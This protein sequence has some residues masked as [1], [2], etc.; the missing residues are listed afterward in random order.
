MDFSSKAVAKLTTAVGKTLDKCM[1]FYKRVLTT[2]N[3]CQTF[4]AKRLQEFPRHEEHMKYLHDRLQEDE[5]IIPQ[6]KGLNE[7]IVKSLV[8]QAV[9]SN[10]LLEDQLRVIPQRVAKIKSQLVVHE[11]LV[12]ILEPM[13]FRTIV[14]DVVAWKQFVDGLVGST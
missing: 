8:A 9:V 2:Q 5:L 13:D 1:D 4:S 14:E 3:R 12:R 11:V 7:K 10:C 6:V